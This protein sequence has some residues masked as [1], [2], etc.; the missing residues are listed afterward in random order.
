MSSL[1]IVTATS[2]GTRSCAFD[3]DP[4]LPRRR[5]EPAVVPVGIEEIDH[6]APH[7]PKAVDK[8]DESARRA[9]R[10]RAWWVAATAQAGLRH[11]LQ[12]TLPASLCSQRPR[13]FR[14]ELIASSPAGV[15][16]RVTRA[17]VFS[18][19]AQRRSSSSMTFAACVCSSLPLN[20]PSV[21]DCDTMGMTTA[22]T[23]G[24][25]HGVPC[26]S[27]LSGGLPLPCPRP[28]GLYPVRSLFVSYDTP[29]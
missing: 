15:L 1:R 18:A 10:D 19:A 14:A 20:R 29:G 8:I 5:I 4:P 24:T 21:I 17:S 7:E 6:R 2:V 3:L 23:I 12:R 26:R 9:S 28:R 22:S 25:R 16:I 13:R 11:D 27:R